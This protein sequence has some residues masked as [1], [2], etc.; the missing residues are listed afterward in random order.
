MGLILT[1]C[2]GGRPESGGVINGRTNS[3]PDNFAANDLLGGKRGSHRWAVV[4]ANSPDDTLLPPDPRSLVVEGVN[5]NR[6]VYFNA[7]WENCHQNLPAEEQAPKTC[8]EWRRRRDLG[9]KFLLDELPVGQITAEAYNDTWKK[10][11]FNERPDRFDEL[12]TLRYGLNYAP[13]HNPYPLPGED[14]N[15][16]NGG[17]GQ[18]PL[19]Y[20]Q[21]RDDQGLWTGNIQTAACFQC[22]GGQIGEPQAGEPVIIGLDNIG[23]GNNNYDMPQVSADGS[24][25]VGTPLGEITPPFDQNI[26]YN[27]GIRQRGQNNA[28]G[29]FEFI[30][31]VL[32]IDSL[33]LNPNPAKMVTPYG[34]QGVFDVS[35]PLAHT[36][37]TPAW[38]NIGSRPRK[39]FD[40]GLSNASTRIIMAAGPGELDQLVT[41]DGALYRQRVEKWD[42]HLDAF[43]LSLESP[44]YPGV[45]DRGL[46]QAG[47]ILFH[48]KNLWEEPSNANA[49]RPD[50]GNG[51][52]ASCHGAYSPR[53]VNDTNYLEDPS[54]EGVAAHLSSLEVIG[55]DRARV[56]MLTTSLRQGWD[57]SYWAYPDGVPGY[58]PPEEKDYLTE[59]IDDLFPNRPT[60]VCGWEKRQG[61]QAPPLYGI[62]ATA[63]YFHNGSV[64][65]IEAVLNSEKRQEIWQRQL[66]EDTG[67]VGFDQSLSTGYDFEAVGWKHYELGCD[68]LPG[69]PLFNCNPLR[70]E[71][72]SMYQ[73]MTNFLYDMVSYTGILAAVDPT[74]N[75]LDRR[76][77]FDTR[78]LGNSNSGHEFS[79]A[80]TDTER[81]AI[82]EYLKTL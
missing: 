8:G 6:A 17:S 23:L 81:K 41:A 79:D 1:A 43:F 24:P 15:T 25:F 12:Y 75:A 32:D 48:S 13:F 72:P 30:N 22:H 47:A 65:T 63:P 52:C 3:R 53:Y 56:D 77:V 50:G 35:H 44:K 5:A 34:I 67:I 16:T 39:F 66:R 82:I 64:P 7:F 42:Q 11:G 27:M 19:G 9:L 49:P 58:V 40:A 20:R 69:D 4:C 57:T 80:L 26:V 73:I 28:V 37:D 59:T 29:G 68:S 55:T 2:N 33:G 18:L 78:I 36:Q 74:P 14:P 54:L 46:A 76:L 62:W 61:Y 70:D 31:T 60:G 21:G 45:I 10:W 51:S 71:G 38:W